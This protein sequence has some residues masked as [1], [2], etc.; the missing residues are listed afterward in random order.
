M[1]C[2]E[3]TLNAGEGYNDI[4]LQK[5]ITG[6]LPNPVYVRQYIRFA[7]LPSVGKVFSYL[8]IA[9]N[10]AHDLAWFNIQNNATY[11][12]RWMLQYRASGASQIIYSTSPPILVDTWYLMEIYLKQHASAAE[13]KFFVNEVNIGS[14][15]GYDNLTNEDAMDRIFSSLGITDPDKIYTVYKDVIKVSDEYIGDEPVKC[16]KLVK[17]PFSSL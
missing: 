3:E 16:M 10:P 2:V 6:G 13:V 17:N 15:S 9:S 8:L 1:Y 4:V 12:L 7:V 14:A 11:G 5:N